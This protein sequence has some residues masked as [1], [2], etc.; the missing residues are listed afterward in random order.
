MRSSGEFVDRSAWCDDPNRG[1]SGATL[2]RCKQ[3]LSRIPSELT[4]LNKGLSTLQ[5]Q[6]FSVSPHNVN[7]V[8]GGTQDNGTWETGGIANNGEN[9]II[10][11]GGQSG[12]DAAIPG[13][14][15][16]T[17]TG[18]RQTRTS[19]AA[20]SRVDRSGGPLGQPAAFYSPVISDPVVSK[21]LF[22]GTQTVFRTKTAGLGSRTIAEAQAICN[23]W[24]GTFTAQCGDWAELGSPRLTNV[25]LG[26]RA[27]GNMAAIERTTADSSSAW[28]ATTTGRVFISKNVAADPA[29][30]V[31]WTRI[32]DDSAA[33][34]GG[35]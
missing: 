25:A 22:A 33:T 12:F 31:T 34:P 19:T 26:S 3:M 32:D 4:S 30:A 28:A 27:G 7:I 24:T 10:G 8:Q 5:F 11:D 6:S 18:P 15:F 17:F 14:R 16:N 20:T 35:S 23:E 1:L 13:F 21:T 9:T 2:A 29:S